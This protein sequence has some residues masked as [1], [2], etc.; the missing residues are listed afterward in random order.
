MERETG[1]GAE[2]EAMRQRRR[3]LE[4]EIRSLRK[5]LA[6]FR[7]VANEAAGPSE[8]GKAGGMRPRKASREGAGGQAERD[9]TD[10]RQAQLTALLEDRQMEL[11]H[12]LHTLSERS[13]VEA[14]VA[15]QRARAAPAGSAPAAWREARHVLLGG[16]SARLADVA[17]RL[18]GI[19]AAARACGLS[20]TRLA[21][22]VQDGRPSDATLALLFEA[23]SDDFPDI[24]E[25]LKEA[26]RGGSMPGRP[27]KV[28]SDAAPVPPRPPAEGSFHQY[29]LRDGNLVPEEDALEEKRAEAA[30]ENARYIVRVEDNALAPLIRPGDVVFVNAN[31]LP[32][33]GDIVLLELLDGR[34][35]L[36]RLLAVE[37]GSVFAEADRDRHSDLAPE[38]TRV[39]GAV[40]HVLRTVP[41]SEITDK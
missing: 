11:G 35:S 28:I 41:A 14:G 34:H 40:T 4:E 8:P 13:A 5:Q 23:F 9:A 12:L 33:P 38:D 17:G 7:G 39:I 31:P 3:M 19:R 37:G 27:P 29:R 18:G 32:G 22:L 16:F 24:P 25:V 2:I 20:H 36:R 1:D 21:R 26:P 10:P 30:R 6:D 15:I